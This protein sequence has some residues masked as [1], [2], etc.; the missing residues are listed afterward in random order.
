MTARMLALLICLLIAVTAAG[1]AETTN[2]SGSAADD[3]AAIAAEDG[4]EVPDVTTL[5]GAD[6]VAEI[7]SAG[8]AAA[9]TGTTDDPGLDTGRDAAGCTVDDQ[10]PAGGDT[11]A[12]GDEV[13]ITV[14][15]RQ[16]DWDNQ[17]GDGW[18]EFST[19]FSEGF[20]QG[21]QALFDLSRDGELHADSS[22]YIGADCT[23]LEPDASDASDVPSDVPDDP[24]AAGEELGLH[25][26]CSA[27]FDSEAITELYWGTDA[28][29]AEDCLDNTAGAMPTP[30]PAQDEATTGR[31]SDSA[32]VT[33]G[34]R[35]EPTT[36]NGDQ[37][38]ITGRQGRV[39]CVGAA[40]LWKAYIDSPGGVGSGGY[41]ELD[42][43][44]CITARPPEAPL[45]G[46]C[47]VSDDSAAFSVREA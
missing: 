3:T 21:C 26:G 17:D 36:V 8:F 20:V 6:A 30:A 25:D 45:L 34:E 11:L 9:L 13:T 1:C 33:S 31:Q 41:L 4:V 46:G 40:A 43:W 29:T 39:R 10:D 32:S 19:A 16:V 24:S 7:E 35:C 27:L 47:T 23:N 44:G 5:D 14:D 15:C 28:Y 42:G 18:D 12:E 37:I 38:R 2:S 22:D